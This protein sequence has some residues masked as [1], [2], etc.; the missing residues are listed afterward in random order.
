MTWDEAKQYVE[1][2]FGLKLDYENGTLLREGDYLDQMERIRLAAM[3]E[4]AE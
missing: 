4:A 2:E 1:R 3:S